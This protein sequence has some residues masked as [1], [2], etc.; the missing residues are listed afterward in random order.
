MANTF[1]VADANGNCC[2]CSQQVDC[3]C[4][5][6]PTCQ[7]RCH[8]RTAAGGASLCGY[9]EYTAIS[10]P[11]KVYRKKTLSGGA[12]Y[13][14][15]APD[16][17]C[18]QTDP[19][20]GSGVVCTQTYVASGSCSYDADTCAFT[21]A[22]SVDFSGCDPST[23]PSCGI[24]GFIVGTSTTDQVSFSITQNPG[25]VVN[26]GGFVTRYFD[27]GTME[28][29]L[30]D[31][32]TPQDAMSRAIAAAGSPP[33]GSTTLC[34]LST[35][36]ISPYAVVGGN[37]TFAF[38]Q[39][40]VQAILGSCD[41]TKTYEITIELGERTTGTSGPFVPYGQL[42]FAFQSQ[43]VGQCTSQWVDIP[44]EYGLEICALSCSVAVSG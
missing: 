22:G 10:N 32:D 15:Y 27:D 42:T 39:A 18:P 4:N 23:N 26:P 11:P 9:P 35:A 17:C 25:C 7:I 14:E 13:I 24:S 28:E 44:A 2:D 40:Q 1:Q 34:G 8:N 21:T 38:Q 36:F 37:Y 16:S 19:G 20:C 6:A 29:I 3:I 31:E 33:W 30:S 43:G 41:Q 12:S 5:G